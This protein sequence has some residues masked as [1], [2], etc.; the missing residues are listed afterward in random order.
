MNLRQM[1]Y[2][3]LKKICL[4][5]IGKYYDNLIFIKKSDKESWK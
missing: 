1:N 2:W 3:K 5:I 4:V